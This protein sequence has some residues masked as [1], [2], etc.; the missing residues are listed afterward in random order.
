MGR[1]GGR[2]KNLGKGVEMNFNW[3]GKAYLSQ[4]TKLDSPCHLVVG[5]GE[6]PEI[7]D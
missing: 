1:K 5:L 7:R 2:K 6:K 3:Q 4:H